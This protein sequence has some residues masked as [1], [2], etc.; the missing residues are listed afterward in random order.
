MK[1]Q[2]GKDSL[3]S[4]LGWTKGLS[5]LTYKRLGHSSLLSQ[6]LQTENAVDR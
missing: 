5:F 4:S 3:P 6:S 1:T 2:L